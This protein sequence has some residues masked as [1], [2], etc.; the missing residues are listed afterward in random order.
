MNLRRRYQGLAV[1]LAVCSTGAVTGQEPSARPERA[2]L[3]PPAISAV[4]NADRS[5]SFTLRSDHAEQVEIGGDFRFGRKMVG[6]E[7]MGNEATG[8]VPSVPMT[9]AG[10]VWAITSEPVSP[11]IYRYFFVVDGTTTPTRTVDVAGPEAMPWD[12][13]DIPH[14]TVVIDKLHSEALKQVKPCVVYL[15][16]GYG[17]STKSYPVLYLLHGGGGGDSLEWVSEGHADNIMDYLISRGRAQEMILVMPDRA[18]LPSAEKKRLDSLS[19]NA[20][21]AALAARDRLRS[22]YLL[23]EVMP[24]IESKYRVSKDRAPSPDCREERARPSSS[25][26][27]IRADS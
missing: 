16:P 14:G 4:V 20:L 24:F 18:L 9:R 5:V 26:P 8:S 23:G 19:G 11:M 1:W 13:L 2:G 22:Q 17:S 10:N 12:L 25:S 21:E 7:A 3:E 6:R 27:R 15:P